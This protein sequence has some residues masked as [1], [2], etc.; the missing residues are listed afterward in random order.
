MYQSSG[1]LTLAEDEGTILVEG[2]GAFMAL[3][4]DMAQS[5]LQEYPGFAAGIEDEEL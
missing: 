3:S 2:Q 4:D 5:L 1:T